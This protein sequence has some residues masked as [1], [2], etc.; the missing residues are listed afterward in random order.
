MQ[1]IHPLF[2]S[3][4]ALVAFSLYDD[5]TPT[6]MQTPA[7]SFSY[8]PYVYGL[9]LF[10]ASHLGFDVLAQTQTHADLIR[11]YQQQ[12]GNHALLYNGEEELKYTRRYL[13][14]PYYRQTDCVP[15]Q[16]WRQG[17]LYKNVD[18]RLDLYKNH[19][20]VRSPDQRFH[21]IIP[22]DEV[23]SVQLHG[24]TFVF[25][26]PASGQNELPAGYYMQLHKGHRCTLWG[27]QWMEITRQETNNVIRI[28]FKTIERYYFFDGKK[29]KTIKNKS[30]LLKQ[31]P[32]RQKEMK[33]YI[34]RNRLNF[35]KNKE[36]AF[37]TMMRYYES[38]P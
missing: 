8:Q 16:L 3:P 33:A 12:A 4:V 23:D 21:L 1:R 24:H 28:R 22:S 18:M 7:I 30:A 36:E 10:L 25:N 5:V 35:R 2:F 32:G 31:M 9:L 38:L 13:N 19:L 37:T 20:I 17:S 14:Q 11:R 29:W 26:H 6:L 15:G 34:K 27:R